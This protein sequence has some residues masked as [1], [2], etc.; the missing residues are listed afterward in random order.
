MCLLTSC[1]RCLGCGLWWVLF[2]TKNETRVPGLEA[3]GGSSVPEL[4]LFVNNIF[5]TPTAAFLYIISSVPQLQLFVY[6]IHAPGAWAGGS[7]GG[8]GFRLLAILLNALWNMSCSDKSC[9]H[10]NKTSD[11]AFCCVVQSFWTC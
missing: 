6:H 10:T 4:Q 2:R 9:T 8:L 7:G 11:S 3:G 5:C 1:T